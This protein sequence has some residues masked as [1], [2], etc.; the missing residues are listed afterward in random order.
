MFNFAVLDDNAEHAASIR[1]IS[2]NYLD[3]IGTEYL[4]FEYTDPN[5]L[6]QD[7]LIIHFS[8]F[9]IDIDLEKITTNGIDVASR[10]NASFPDSQIIFITAYEK[11]YIDSYKAEHIYLVPKNRVTELLPDAIDK[12]LTVIKQNKTHSLLIRANKKNYQ[13]PEHSIR[14]LE[15]NLRKVLIYGEETIQCY[16]KLEDILSTSTSGLLVQCHKSF[17]VNIQFIKS[18]EKSSCVLMNGTVIPVSKRYRSDI[19]KKLTPLS[20]GSDAK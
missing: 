3:S 11:Y 20:G 4:F 6:L 17:A 13:I 16:A 19:L 18:L 7:I 2:S 8:V 5:K 15:K 14:Y 9:L 10:I 12:A 1:N